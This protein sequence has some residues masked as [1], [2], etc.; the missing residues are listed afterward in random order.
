QRRT[1]WAAATSRHPTVSTGLV[2]FAWRS[3]LY[4]GRFASRQICGFPIH[5]HADAGAA[6]GMI[7][8]DEFLERRWIELAISS[9]SQSY[10][11]HGV[12]LAKVALR[13]GAYRKLRSEEHTSELQSRSE[14]VCRLLL[15]KKKNKYKHI[16]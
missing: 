1:T 15:E 6:A 2:A 9:E 8:K 16:H 11:R 10:L 12:R 3:R 13:L 14:L 5:C 7:E 4:P